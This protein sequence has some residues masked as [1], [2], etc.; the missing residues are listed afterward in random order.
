MNLDKEG[1][2]PN[3]VLLNTEVTFTPGTARGTG[4]LLVSH[5]PD[6]C[7]KPL[8]A[9][10]PAGQEVMLGSKIPALLSPQSDHQ[11][12]ST[13]PCSPRA[14]QALLWLEAADDTKL[15]HSA[16][17]PGQ[18]HI[19][20]LPLHPW[21]PFS[22][23]AGSDSPLQQLFSASAALSTS[24]A[25]PCFAETW[26][27]APVPDRDLTK[28]GLQRAQ[29]ADGAGDAA[30][31]WMAVQGP[32]LQGQDTSPSPPAALPQGTE[33]AKS[34]P[35]IP[36]TPWQPCCPGLQQPRTPRGCGQVP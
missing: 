15:T 5:V 3:S 34:A 33:V 26:R 14:S 23:R 11:C 36:W 28:H 16:L 6:K 35:A 12:C 10:A 19:Q 8:K 7:F 21:L 9:E 25:L 4:P 31:V 1:K 30:L 20:P 13:Y 32:A 24:S 18:T 2:W 22:P 17:L 29:H 27:A